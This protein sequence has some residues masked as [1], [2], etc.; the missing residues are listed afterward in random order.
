[1][2]RELEMN[3]KEVLSLLILVVI[4]FA[5]LREFKF[6]EEYLSVLTNILGEIHQI[7]TTYLS[8]EKPGSPPNP[9]H[10]SN[11]GHTNNSQVFNSN[12]GS[13]QNSP[14]QTLQH[15]LNSNQLAVAIITGNISPARLPI[16]NSQA[17][18]INRSVLMRLERLQAAISRLGVIADQYLAS[19]LISKQ[20]IKVFA[21]YLKIV[22]RYLENYERLDLQL[23]KKIKQS[24]HDFLAQKPLIYGVEL[25]LIFRAKKL[26]TL[27]ESVLDRDMKI[28]EAKNSLLKYILETDYVMLPKRLF[29]S[30]KAPAVELTQAFLWQFSDKSKVSSLK[31]H[32]VEC[33]VEVKNVTDDSLSKL[34]VE[35]E[36]KASECIFEQVKFTRK[37]IKEAR[38]LVSFHFLVQFDAICKHE[39]QLSVRLLSTTGFLLDR[40]EAKEIVEVV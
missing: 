30:S 38:S 19:D 20:A 14:A 28:S 8:D 23:I 15:Q 35:A 34:T 13:P 17:G 32:I 3:C 24:L 25:Y 1:M 10:S 5:S 36:L 22:F 11:G 40:I 4:I 27:I 2:Q 9:L 6:T 18:G 39:L 12:H 21:A 16:H 29:I 26:L 37:S 7:I 31:E 33:E